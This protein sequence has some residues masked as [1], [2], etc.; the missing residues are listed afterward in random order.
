MGTWDL[1]FIQRPD[2]VTGLQ[3]RVGSYVTEFKG[4]FQERFQKEHLLDPSDAVPQNQHGIHR[5]GS[6]VAY[7]TELNDPDPTERPYADGTT[8]ILLTDDDRGRLLVKEE[9][10]LYYYKNVTDAWVKLELTQVGAINIWPGTV[11]PENW[12]V[13]NGELLQRDE[14]PALFDICGTIYGT[15]SATDFRIPDLQGLIPMGQGQ[16]DIDTRTK[17]YLDTIGTVKEDRIQTIP[18][19]VGLHPVYPDTNMVDVVSG[20]FVK[21]N[22]TGGSPRRMDRAGGE[23][24]SEGF[25]IDL[26]AGDVRHGTFGHPSVMLMYY[27][28]KVL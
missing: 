26:S 24:N 25:D 18:G 22:N 1:N 11:I 2:S 17:G 7:V 8:P 5:I 10:D 14:F 6:A 9:R 12:K 23:S 28:I 13:C 19:T 3:R 16:Q 20:V 15:E 27:I 21:N 4:N